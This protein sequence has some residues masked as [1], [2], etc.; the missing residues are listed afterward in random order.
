MQQ[1]AGAAHLGPQ[2]LRRS[3]ISHQVHAMVYQSLLQS[4]QHGNGL[5]WHAG[6]S[7]ND[8]MSKTMDL[9]VQ[10]LVYPH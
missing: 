8:R 6:V 7:V 2:Q 9:Y 5:T 1:M 10:P 3:P 4:S